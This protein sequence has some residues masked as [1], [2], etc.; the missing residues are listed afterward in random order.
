MLSS[1]FAVLVVSENLTQT[2]V[3]KEDRITCEEW[4]P[5]DLLVR[6]SVDQFPSLVIE[7]GG[8]N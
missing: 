4:P 1:G 8:A 2:T 5:S 7:L 3:I 6:M